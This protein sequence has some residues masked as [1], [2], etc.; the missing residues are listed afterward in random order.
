MIDIEEAKQ[1]NKIII[2][3]NNDKIILNQDDDHLNFLRADWISESVRLGFLQEMDNYKSKSKSESKQEPSV[4]KEFKSSTD[5]SDSGNDDT[6]NLD[7]DFDYELAQCQRPTPLVSEHN[8]DLIDELQKIAKARYLS[9][10]SRSEQSYKKAIA[11]IKS[12]PNLIKSGKEAQRLKGIGG[13]VAF[14]IDEFIKTGR[15]ELAKELESDEK[16]K[17]IGN[18]CGIHGVGP[19]TAN[20]WYQEGFRSIPD[21]LREKEKLS[22]LTKQQKIGIKYFKDFIVP[23]NRKEVENIHEIV[24]EQVK[25]IF[26]DSNESWKVI[27]TGGY[28]RGKVE[29]NDVDL[30]IY[31]DSKKVES[32]KGQLKKLVNGMMKNQIIQ[33]VILFSAYEEEDNTKRK[34]AKTKTKRDDVEHYDKVTF[35]YYS[36]HGTIMCRRSAS[37]LLKYQ[38]IHIIDGSILFLFR[39]RNYHFAF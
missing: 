12:Y 8:Q 10:N 11:A 9:S 26:N 22:T 37:V 35:Y 17:I 33:D 15:I 6:N 19:S 16:L 38:M 5:E 34:K 21:I 3:G 27:I 23:M 24:K 36:S 13:K 1:E 39:I 29:N 14:L 7:F 32:T 20:K 4:L 2:V 18:F 30:L 28:S 25:V 31:S